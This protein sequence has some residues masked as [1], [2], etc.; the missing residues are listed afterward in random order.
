MSS[1]HKNVYVTLSYRNTAPTEALS[2]YAEEKI[3]NCV[4]KYVHQDTDVQVVLS[5][6]K[7]RQIAEATFHSDGANFA[8]KQESSDLYVSIDQLVDSLTHQL[9]KHKDKITSHHVSK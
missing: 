5:V 4:Q 9:R 2:T 1:K 8:G 3:K 6:E 7:N